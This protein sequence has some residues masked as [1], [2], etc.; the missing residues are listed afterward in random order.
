MSVAQQEEHVTFNDGVLGSS[1]SGHTN[2]K[3]LAATK[4]V[5]GDLDALIVLLQ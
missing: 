1:P 2:F 3:S 5:D 4:L